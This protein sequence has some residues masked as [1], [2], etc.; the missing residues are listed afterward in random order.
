MLH[1]YKIFIH[2]ITTSFRIN[3]VLLFFVLTQSKV[4]KE[5]SRLTGILCKSYDL[6]LFPEKELIRLPIAIGS[7]GFKQLFLSICPSHKIKSCFTTK[8]PECQIYFSKSHILNF[9]TPTI[10]CRYIFN[11]A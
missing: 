10:S 8:I 3:F 4:T 6:I 1:K 5:K 9:F 11:F 2:I 7:G